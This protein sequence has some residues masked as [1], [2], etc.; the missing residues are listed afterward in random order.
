MTLKEIRYHYFLL[1]AITLTFLALFAPQA[2]ATTP[3]CNPGMVCPMIYDPVCGTDGQTYSNSCDAAR[4]CVDVA[5]NGVCGQQPP[6]CVD[7]DL[8]GYSS[9][10]GNC[11]PVDCNDFNARI[12]PGLTCYYYVYAPVCGVDGVTYP[13]VCEAEGAC[14][15]IAH[16]G[17]CTQPPICLDADLDGYSST[18][19][20]C[21]PVDCNDFNP[22]IHPGFICPY[23]LIYAP[24]CGVDGMT[25]DSD[26]A[27]EQACM[28]IAHEGECFQPPT[29]TDA[30]AD[31][32]SPVGGACGT[33]DCNDSD[34]TVNPDMACPMFYAPVCGVDGQTYGNDCLATQACMEIAHTGECFQ[35]PTCTDADAD[36]F[37][38]EGGACGPIDCNDLDPATNPGAVEIPGNNTDENCNGLTDDLYLLGPSNDPATEGSCSGSGGMYIT[39]GMCTP[40]AMG[41][42]FI[43]SHA[44]LAAVELLM[45]NLNGVPATILINIRAGNLAGPILGS[46]TYVSDPTSSAQNWLGWAHFE[47]AAPVSLIPGDVYVIELLHDT[48]TA[49]AWYWLENANCDP[50]VSGFIICN[51]LRATESFYYRTFATV[52]IDADLDGFSPPDD[53]NDADA[54]INPAAGEIPYNGVDE[55]CSGPADDSDFDQDGYPFSEDCDDTDP[56]I[57]PGMICPALYAPVCGSDGNTYGNACAAA[58]AC[59]AIAAQGSCAPLCTDTDQDGFAVEGND[60]GP[61]DCDDGNF[62]VHPGAV[63]LKNN[64]IDENCNGLGDDLEVLPIITKAAY[65]KKGRTLTVT[66]T[67]RLGKKDA[68]VVEGFGAMGWD[69]RHAS[70]TLTINKLSADQAPATVTVTGLYGSSTIS[71]TRTR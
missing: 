60:C 39:T 38:V 18:G 42:E 29:C 34:P 11:G 16:N 57:N 50:A 62:S 26:C 59:V 65:S 55:N 41:Q 66:A 14:M 36:G 45:Q 47:F 22:N 33:V 24:V 48:T 54:A 69:R 52:T 43:A 63:E 51:R 17:E 7:A 12:N 67:S 44:N 19:G 40:Q 58:Q 20:N 68:L 37:A 46:A 71:T 61:I 30:D 9:T 3:P 23:S 21:G 31:G 13:G 27:A 8:D 28:E 2:G 64:Q 49:T 1:N 32:F 56:A 6:T 53:C 4:Y 5:Y 35:P 25:Y 10:G 70:W 15:P